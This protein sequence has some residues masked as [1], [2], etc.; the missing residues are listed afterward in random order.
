MKHSKGSITLTAAQRAAIIA[1]MSK[2]QAALE[3]DRFY[4]FKDLRAA[5]L[6]ILKLTKRV[7]AL[8]TSLGLHSK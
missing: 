7:R 5:K 8:E 4:A 1:T 3:L 6:E 2:Y